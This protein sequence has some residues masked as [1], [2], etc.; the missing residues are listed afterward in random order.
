MI[1]GRCAGRVSIQTREETPPGLTFTATTAHGGCPYLPVPYLPP[2]IAL[3]ADVLPLL[4]MMKGTSQPSQSDFGAGRYYSKRKAV[5]GVC[6]TSAVKREV[7]QPL[8]ALPSTLF[9][10]TCTRTANAC[11]RRRALPQLW[12]WCHLSDGARKPGLTSKQASARSQPLPFTDMAWM[13]AAM[14][15]LRARGSVR[16]PVP[17]KSPAT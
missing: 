8:P 1:G 10:R 13:P 16:W 12:C 15:C 7:L 3:D 5:P 2:P 6:S 9:Y 4:R 11:A 17:A 14:A